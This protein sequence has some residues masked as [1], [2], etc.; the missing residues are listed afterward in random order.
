MSE[1]E[2]R[3][4]YKDLIIKELDR[5]SIRDLKLILIFARG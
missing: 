3:E 5:A 4:F 2:I 1:H